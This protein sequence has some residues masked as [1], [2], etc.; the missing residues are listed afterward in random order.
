M[1][2]DRSDLEEAV[3]LLRALKTVGCGAHEIVFAAPPDVA[4]DRTA[5]LARHPEKPKLLGCPFCGGVPELSTPQKG[6]GSMRRGYCHNCQVYGPWGTD[7]AD[8]TAAWNRRATP[9]SGPLSGG[10]PE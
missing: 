7:T 4:N 6:Y 9:A 1:S 2:D 3:R 8:A 5:F 10:K